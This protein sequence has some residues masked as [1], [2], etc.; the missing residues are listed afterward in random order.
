MV[1]VSSHTSDGAVAV[2]PHHEA[3]AAALRIMK[4]GGSAADAVVAANAVLGMV[5]PTTCGIGGD[6]FAIVHAPGMSQP[7]VLNASG[8]GGSGIDSAAMRAAGHAEIPLYA[9]ESVTVPGAVD[10]W[11][12][13]LARH[14]RMPLSDL[15][16]DAIALGHEGFEASLELSE[17]LTRL[18]N[19]LGEQPSARALYPNDGPP[20]PGH[21]L[22][23]PDLAG[24]LEAIASD[25]RAALYEGPIAAAISAA[26]GGILS[27]E[28][29]ASNRSDWVDA[30]GIE[31]FGVQ[32]WTVPPNTQGYLTLGALWL[33][34]QL[35]PPRDP[36]D[37]RFHHAVIEA[38]RSVAWERDDVVADARFAPWPP[39]RYLDPERL[40]ARL[41]EIDP[42]R[43]R[44]WPCRAPRATSSK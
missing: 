36:S 8:R 41:G 34:E 38:Y 29:L 4:A 1:T 7:D 13:L 25:G 9:P 5:L 43:A 35:D 21:T 15:L 23:R 33:V 16:R 10:G 3:T 19:A 24:S 30:I 44:D 37:P 6:L 28:D 22:R 42:L 12:T 18:H 26:T 11:E 27:P 31:V 2:T 40:R 20:S 14:G 17:G 39:D 32:G